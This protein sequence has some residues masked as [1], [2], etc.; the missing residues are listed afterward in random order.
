MSIL[1]P[2]GQ[3]QLRRDPSDLSRTLIL[4]NGEVVGSIP[5]QG[6]DEIA[7]SFVMAARTGEQYAKAAEIAQADALLIRTGA[8]FALSNDP[9]IREE[10]YKEAQW[11]NARKGMPLLGVPSPKAVGTPSVIKTRKVQ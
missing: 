8:P 3:L 5:W 11:G 7:K 6:C 10:A 4:L 2:R 9:K 1:K